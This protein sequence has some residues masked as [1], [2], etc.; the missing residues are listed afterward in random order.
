MNANARFVRLEIVA[1]EEAYIVRRDDRTIRRGGDLQD[2]VEM[3]RLVGMSDARHFEIPAIAEMP[4]PFVRACE[5]GL[6]FVG[7]Q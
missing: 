3:M 6:V 2:T 4:Q 5:R 1:R 7:Q